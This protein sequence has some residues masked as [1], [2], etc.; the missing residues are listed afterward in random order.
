MKMSF[1]IYPM[2]NYKDDDMI[3]IIRYATRIFYSSQC[4][5]ISCL[6][7]EYEGFIKILTL[8]DFDDCKYGCCAIH[9]NID[10]QTKLAKDL[11]NFLIDQTKNLTFKLSFDYDR[12]NDLKE[13]WWPVILNGRLDMFDDYVFRYH[14]AI[15]CNGNCD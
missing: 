7:P 4:G 1:D 12:L 5:G 9:S 15:L 14:Q 10:L 13:G 11:D 6:H 2:S 8:D 3:L